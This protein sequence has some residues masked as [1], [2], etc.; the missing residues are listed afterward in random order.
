MRLCLIEYSMRNIFLEKPYTKCGGET[1][2]RPISK[3][4]KLSISL[5]TD[6]KQLKYK[7]R[8]AYQLKSYFYQHSIL[9]MFQL[10]RFERAAPILSFL[11]ASPVLR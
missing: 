9:H 5:D 3:K 6:L 7:T 1:I 4:S 2:P 10:S 8:S 11:P